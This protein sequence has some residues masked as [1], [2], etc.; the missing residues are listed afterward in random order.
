MKVYPSTNIRNVGIVAHGGAGK[1]SLTEA[2]LYNTGATK[3][4]G[5][6]DEGNTVTDYHPEEIKRKVTINTSL[7]FAEWQDHK[8]N[9]LDTPGYSD[10]FGDVVSALRVVD[11]VLVVVSAVAGVEVQTEVVWEEAEARHLPRL[12]YVNKMDRENANFQKAVESMRERLSGRIVPV[13]LPI[14]AAET[15]SGVIDILNQK[16]YTYNDNGNEKEGPVPAEYADEV[17]SL[18]E[19]LVEA[20]AEGDDELLM[21]YL[22]GEELTPDEVRLGLKKAIAEGKV[23]PVLCGSALKNMGVKPLLDYIVDYLPSP[24]DVAGKTA[25]ELEKESLA[26]LVF[27]TLA[28]PY[29]GRLSMFRVYSG[30]LKS[31][32]SVYNANRESEEKIGQLFALQ[33]KNQVA[34]A[35]MRPGDMGA[36]AKLQVTTTGDTLSAKADPVQLEGINFPEPTLPVAIRPKSKGD[37]DKLSNALARLLEEDPTL[38]LS[39]NTETRETILTGMGESHLDITLERLQRK[40]GVE[41]EM[42]TPRVPYRETIRTSVTRVEGKHK[43][44]TGGHGQYGHVFIDM[45]PLP[46]KEFEFT[47]T[48]FGGAVPRQYIPAVEKGIREAMQEGILAG[49]PVTNI[50]VNLADGSYHTVDSSEMAFKIAAG[51]AFRKAVEQAKP[52]LLEPIMNVEIT[53]PEQFM[54]DIMGDLNSRRGRILG[55]EPKGKNQV[56]RAQVPL[57]EMYRYAIN[58]KSITQGRGH[59][60]MDFAQYEEVPANIAEKIIQ[61]ARREKEE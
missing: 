27:K 50:K 33:G 10:F 15:F 34:V 32:S 37:E 18:R 5:R 16:A 56:I 23:V 45:A 47:E 53:V 36:V 9:I 55:M 59:F 44:Q 52:V 57:A 14:G 58:L 1:T 6:V 25:A 39:K 42:S 48:I 54:G 31:D 17:A 51:I 60:K 28:D 61:E 38:R 46:D 29:V 30:I 7:A 3:R 20:A 35:E 49:Y 19:A 41:V 4:L 40:F 12:A 21:K 13:Q 22:E 43:K 24:V 8:I 26:A 2:L 11:S